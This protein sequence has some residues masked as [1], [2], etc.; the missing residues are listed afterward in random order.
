MTVVLTL[1]KFKRETDFIN[2]LSFEFWFKK[3]ETSCW[4]SLRNTIAHNTSIL[5]EFDA[6]EIWRKEKR[7]K[8]NNNSEK[9]LCFIQLNNDEWL[10]GG[11]KFKVSLEEMKEKT[12][13]NKDKHEEIKEASI[14]MQ[15]DEKTFITGH[16]PGY[17][18]KRRTMRS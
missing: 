10:S 14:A 15:Q 1:F 4:F 6:F 16:C 13:E 8:G 2:I 12:K 17:N 18:K 3:E 5:L 9:V 11:N 7:K